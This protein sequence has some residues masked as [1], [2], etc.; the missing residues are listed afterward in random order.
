MHQPGYRISLAHTSP[1]KP[2]EPRGL[3]K[4]PGKIAPSRFN[5]DAGGK[6]ERAGA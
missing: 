6:E 5:A 2:A 4:A 3:T 1:R